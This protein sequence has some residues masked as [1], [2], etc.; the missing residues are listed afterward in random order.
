MSIYY[1]TVPNKQATETLIGTTLE[2]YEKDNTLIGAL[3]ILDTDKFK[4]INDTYGIKKQ[5]KL[6]TSS[7]L[8]E[9]QDTR[10]TIKNWKKN[11]THNQNIL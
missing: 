2:Q 4:H 8:T 3:M 9:E 5:I 6:Y 1:V 10:S 11:R 7:R